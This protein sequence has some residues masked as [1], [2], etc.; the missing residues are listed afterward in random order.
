MSDS[1][2]SSKFELNEPVHHTLHVEDDLLNLT[3]QK[4]QLTRFPEELD[5]VA[6][7]DWGQGSKVKV[8]RDL[9]EYWRDGY[10]WRAEEVP[11]TVLLHYL[12]N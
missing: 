6:D 7:D 11:I 5:D 4:L 12:C 8:V 3:K 9:A 2:A 1:Q 10:D